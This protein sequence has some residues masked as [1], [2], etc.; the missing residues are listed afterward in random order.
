M[1]E[2]KEAQGQEQE[3]QSSGRLGDFVRITIMLW[4]MAIITA[5]YLGFFKG[6]R[7]DFQCIVIEFNGC[8][9]RFN[10]EQIGQE[11]KR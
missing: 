6:S 2:T 8:E 10:D 7:C 5:N 4:A 3:D 11:E 9:L 1:A